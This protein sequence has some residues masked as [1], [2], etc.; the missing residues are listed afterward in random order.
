MPEV[1]VAEDNADVRDFLSAALSGAGY[2]V[3]EADDGA[4]ALTR[5]GYAP[6]ALV[7]LDLHMPRVDG[8]EVLRR[9]RS[10]PAWATT[11]VL[12]LT[13]SGLTEDLVEARRLGARGYLVK[14][15][16]PADLVAKVRRIIDDPELLWIDD[17]TEL[18]AR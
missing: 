13:A 18:R 2:Q 5:L 3:T 10:V 11:P 7:L 14:P 8:M 16:R 1:L 17:I 6:P 12:F 4:A 15:I 9:M